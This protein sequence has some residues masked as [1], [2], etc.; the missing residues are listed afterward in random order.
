MKKLLFLAAVCAAVAFTSCGKGEKAAEAVDSDTID[1]VE[2]VIDVALDTV[3]NQVDTVVTTA[4]EAVEATVP[5][6]AAK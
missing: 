3:G 1:A 6:E 5:A 4:V 2:G